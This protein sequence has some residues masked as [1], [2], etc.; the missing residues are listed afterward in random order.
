M[1][2]TSSP[3]W[4]GP[5]PAEIEK[6][7]AHVERIETRRKAA[8]KRLHE[9]GKRSSPTPKRLKKR[10]VARPGGA[11]TLAPIGDDDP[12]GDGMGRLFFLDEPGFTSSALPSCP[13][14]PGAVDDDEMDMCQEVGADDDEFD[15]GEWYMLTRASDTGVGSKHS[16]YLI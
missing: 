12:A 2:C 10:S 13:I 1:E 4:E 14:T 5:L 9:E 11:A 8:A 16:K 3:D 7:P 6:D 15:E